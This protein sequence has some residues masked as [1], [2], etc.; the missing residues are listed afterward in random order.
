MWRRRKTSW[1]FLARGGC[2]LFGQ[3]ELWAA[4]QREE[5]KALNMKR[6]AAWDANRVNSCAAHFFSAPPSLPP[7]NANK[8]DVPNAGNTLW[9]GA[10]AHGADADAAK[11]TANT[12]A[13]TMSSSCICNI[14]PDLRAPTNSRETITILFVVSKPPALF[15][16]WRERKKQQRREG[17]SVCFVALNECHFFSPLFFHNPSHPILHRRW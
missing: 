11:L 17:C 3:W 1:V 7:E 6:H 12:A 13:A 16:F 5:K 10:N 15:F 14:A 2:F 8:L 4:V 9:S